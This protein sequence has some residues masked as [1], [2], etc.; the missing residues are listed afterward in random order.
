MKYL[1]KTKIGNKEDVGC[2]FD[3]ATATQ[4]YRLKLKEM[5]FPDEINVEIINDGDS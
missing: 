1:I 4:Y 3:K 5:C 2:M